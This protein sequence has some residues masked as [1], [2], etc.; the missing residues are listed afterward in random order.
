MIP[1]KLIFDFNL[2]KQNLPHL[3]SFPFVATL[4]MAKA[5]SAS[6]FTAKPHASR[7]DWLKNVKYRCFGKISTTSYYDLRAVTLDLAKLFF[8]MTMTSKIATRLREL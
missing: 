8:E 7:M 2:F 6:L 3:F 1:L 4:D 5:D